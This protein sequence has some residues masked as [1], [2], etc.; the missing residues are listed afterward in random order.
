M[1]PPKERSSDSYKT[2]EQKLPKMKILK[3][4]RPNRPL[5]DMNNTVR[6]KDDSYFNVFGPMKSFRNGSWT[7]RVNRKIDIENESNLSDFPFENVN[8]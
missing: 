2:P 1:V 4:D 3:S 7:N 5:P 6:T 8:N